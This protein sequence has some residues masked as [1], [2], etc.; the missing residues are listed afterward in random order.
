M[1]STSIW[2]PEHPPFCSDFHGPALHLLCIDHTKLAVSNN[3]IQRRLTD[4][5]GHVLKRI[6]A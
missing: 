3:G 2:L 1:A 6:L 4:V 5:Y